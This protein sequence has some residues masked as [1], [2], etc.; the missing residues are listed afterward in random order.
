[1][2]IRINYVAVLY[3]SKS[4]LIRIEMK[5]TE[6]RTL[7][8]FH[9]RTKLSAFQ[10][11]LL[12]QEL[13]AF[14]LDSLSPNLVPAQFVPSYS[15]LHKTPLD[16]RQM[17]LNLFSIYLSGKRSNDFRSAFDSGAKEHALQPLRSKR[18][19]VTAPHSGP[20]EPLSL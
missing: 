19:I 6:V 20:M 4:E 10:E 1:M 12:N 13:F 14:F 5:V 18:N 9:Q 17:G 16:K 15:T 3:S 8:L 7:H 11:Q 2:C